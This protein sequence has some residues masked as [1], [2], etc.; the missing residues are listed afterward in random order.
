MAREKILDEI[1]PEKQM[2]TIRA[3]HA[4]DIH[5]LKA[6]TPALLFVKTDWCP[7]CRDAKPLIDKVAAALGSTVQVVAIDGDKSKRLVQQL[8]VSTYPTLIAVNSKGIKRFSGE[9]TFDQIIGFVCEYA[10]SGKYCTA[11]P[12]SV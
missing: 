4:E 3:F 8:G 9:R 12:K 2:T 6:L 11:K 10:A 7:Y 1:T 5:A